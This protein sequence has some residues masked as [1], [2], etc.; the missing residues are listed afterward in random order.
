M[1]DTNAEPEMVCPPSERLGPGSIFG[2]INF[3]AYYLGDAFD[4]GALQRVARMVPVEYDLIVVGA[5]GEV[6]RYLTA[7]AGG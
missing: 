6:L 5:P 7:K 1:S 3:T 4:G 2:F